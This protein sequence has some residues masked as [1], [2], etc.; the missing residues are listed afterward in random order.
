MKSSE[1]SRHCPVCGDSHTEAW[2]CKE[3]LN[4]VRCRACSMIYANPVPAGFASGQFYADRGADYYLSPAKLQSDYATVRFDR[5]L[6]LFREY[7]RQGAVLDVGCS[8]GAFLYQLK[9][10]FPGNYE[11]LGTDVSGPPLDHAEAM[12]IPV[13]RGDFP[14]QIFDKTKFE[15]VT[16]WAVIEHLPDPKVFLSKAFALLK[17]GGVCFVLVPNMKSLAVRLLEA[18]YR[19]IL[20]QHLNYFTPATLKKLVETERGV[21]VIHLSASHFNPLVILQDWRRSGKAVPEAERALLLQRTTRY[22]QKPILKPVRLL[23]TGVE[24]ILSRLYLADN[25]VMVV[26]KT[27]D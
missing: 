5:E 26:R 1:V 23:L 22:K 25:L 6:R 24:M 9:S 7:C 14:E 10:R 8:S 18:K 21:E 3:E 12:G 19:Y 15:A 11:L 13:V 16:F 17:P 27:A 2:L 20:P 4:L